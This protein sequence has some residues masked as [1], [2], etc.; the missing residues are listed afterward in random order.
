MSGGPGALSGVA[1]LT[2]IASRR[3]SRPNCPR[4]QEPLINTRRIAVAAGLL[5]GFPE[6]VADSPV[7]QDEARK[8]PSV[9]RLK[10]PR[11]PG[12]RRQFIDSRIPKASR[13]WARVR[14]VSCTHA[15]DYCIFVAAPQRQAGRQRGKEGGKEGGRACGRAG[16][17]ASA[18]AR[19]ARRFRSFRRLVSL[20]S[21]SPVYSEHVTHR[22]GM[23]RRP[24]QPS[25]PP[26]PRQL[27]LPSPRASSSESEEKT[28]GHH[29]LTNRGEG[30]EG[31]RRRR[32]WGRAGA[33][34]QGVSCS[35]HAVGRRVKGGGSHV[36]G[37]WWIMRHGRTGEER[38]L[39]D[40]QRR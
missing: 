22:S 38:A 21:C 8:T 26:H 5:E 12:K 37:N 6:G 32:G 7:P 13:V 39:Q 28:S 25:F 31:R 35:C 11:A 29:I 33:R 14:R 2:R 19:G 3:D 34:G 36:R 17:Q 40:K 20:A 27:P 16:A 15:I 24:R 9:V 30:H 10:R 4:V 23:G 1:P 18:P